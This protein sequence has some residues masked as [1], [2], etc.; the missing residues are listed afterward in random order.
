[1]PVSLTPFFSLVMQYTKCEVAVSRSRSPRR[2]F[3][4]HDDDTA[5]AEQS[6]LARLRAAAGLGA[7]SH[8]GKQGPAAAGAAVVVLIAIATGALRLAKRRA[9]SLKDKQRRLRQTITL[10]GFTQVKLTALWMGQLQS[11]FVQANRRLRSRRL[12][13][14]SPSVTSSV[15][16]SL[17]P[18]LSPPFGLPGICLF[19]LPF[20][21]RLS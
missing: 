1:M 7:G 8:S 9:A 12:S 11:P 6:K 2:A 4:R 5:M 10:E 15:R 17:F 13:S 14:S 19:A 20:T 16:A 3:T 21:C 18:S